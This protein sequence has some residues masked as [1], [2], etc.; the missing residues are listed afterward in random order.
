MVL[1]TTLGS[2][3]LQAFWAHPEFQEYLEEV[4]VSTEYKGILPNTKKTNGK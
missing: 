3:S 1:D 4:P 2:E